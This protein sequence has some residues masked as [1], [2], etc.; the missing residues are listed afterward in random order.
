MTTAVHPSALDDAAILAQCE[1]RPGRGGGPGGQHRNKVQTK[2]T[3]L[4]TPTGLTA[5]ASERRSASENKKEALTR[6]RLLL[7][8]QVR[9]PVPAGEART[10]LWMS[11][12]RG[13]VIACN[14]E[15]RDYPA[16]LALA[17]DVLAACGWEP[18]EAAL[19]LESSPSQLVKL[20][21]KHPP[22]LELL[23]KERAAL[24]LR[25]LRG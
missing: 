18:K 11:R 14:P 20:L 2:V 7:A 19:R 17:L 12:V 6:L 23:N 5:Q 1:L 13:G 3:L 15:H 8:L 21:A 10:P 22:A 9:R 4:H 16:M 25:P 24:G